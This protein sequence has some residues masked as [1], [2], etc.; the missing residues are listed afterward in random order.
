MKNA[1]S[2]ILLYSLFM[3]V[4]CS[5]G[6]KKKKRGGLFPIKQNGQHGYIDQT[7]ETVIQPQFSSA[8]DFPKASHGSVS[9][10]TKDMLT[11]RAPIN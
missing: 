6:S 11:R 10:R 1:A 4:S 5:N 8:G 7:G 3:I 2:L 9:A